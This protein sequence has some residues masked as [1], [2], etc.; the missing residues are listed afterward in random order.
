VAQTCRFRQKLAT[1]L[2]PPLTPGLMEPCLGWQGVADMLPPS[3]CEPM[4]HVQVGQRV[5][6]VCAVSERGQVCQPLWSTSEPGHV[7]GPVTA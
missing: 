7:P 1:C 6:L 2:T 3:T 4:G 5:S